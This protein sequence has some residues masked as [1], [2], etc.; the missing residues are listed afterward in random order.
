M[1]RVKKGVSDAERGDAESEVVFQHR[2][3]AFAVAEHEDSWKIEVVGC[4][5]SQFVEPPD[6]KVDVPLLVATSK[7]DMIGAMKS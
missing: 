1:T 7:T 5:Q 2:P 3:A 6:R 4:G